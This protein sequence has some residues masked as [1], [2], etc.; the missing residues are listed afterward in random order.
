MSIWLT[1][2]GTSTSVAGLLDIHKNNLDDEMEDFMEQFDERLKER[3]SSAKQHQ[4]RL[5]ALLP[6]FDSEAEALKYAKRLTMLCVMDEV[7]VPCRGMLR[8][9]IYVGRDKE[10]D[11]KVLVYNP[12]TKALDSM[13]Y[14]WEQIVLPT[15]DCSGGATES[16]GPTGPQG[17]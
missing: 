10:G 14:C 7:R 3:L 16:V 17:A 12:E 4:A 9:G 2:L 1:Q 11:A 8:V 13:N 6:K 5:K 15:E